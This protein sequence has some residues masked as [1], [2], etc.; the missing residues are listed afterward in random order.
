MATKKAAQAAEA[1]VT[2][3]VQAEEE[4]KEQATAQPA[5]SQ[6]EKENEELKTMLRDMQ[7]MMESMK[8]QMEE[9][10]EQ[11]RKMAAGEMKPE[12][13]KS[14]TDIDN[15]EL[16]RIATEAAEAGKNA[17]DVEVEIFVPHRDKGEDRW[18]WL[19]INDR[20]AQI[21]ADDRRQKMKLPFALIL[22]GM[23]KAK[24]REEEYID[25][26][27]V[28]DPISNPHQGRL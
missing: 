20:S 6:A 18:Y 10:Q 12:R 8:T 17:W 4:T 19:N 16:Q 2:E 22:S 13:P 25:N 9:Q 3:A 1:E 21:P 27:Q 24:Q 5:P 14:Q 7:K 15:E 26:V 23:L 11:I 28:Y